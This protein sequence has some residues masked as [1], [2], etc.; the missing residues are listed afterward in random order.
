M[1]ASDRLDA[2]Q[3][4]GQVWLVR[5]GS[6]SVHRFGGHRLKHEQ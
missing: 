1:T 4:N 6:R 2:R 5:I 3:P